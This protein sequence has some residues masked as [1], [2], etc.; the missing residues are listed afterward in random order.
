MNN[1]RFI[2]VNK[3]V[4]RQQLGH[5]DSRLSS[6]NEIVINGNEDANFNHNVVTVVSETF[7]QL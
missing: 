3:F 1:F 7:I 4:V 5:D 6:V 2:R